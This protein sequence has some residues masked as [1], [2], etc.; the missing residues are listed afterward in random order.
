MTHK[1]HHYSHCNA[2]SISTALI[3]LF[4]QMMFSSNLGPLVSIDVARDTPSVQKYDDHFPYADKWY[5]HRI[6]EQGEYTHSQHRKKETNVHMIW[7]QL[8]FRTRNKV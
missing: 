5:V 1:P 3:T 7:S 2:S 4:Y 8:C 6:S